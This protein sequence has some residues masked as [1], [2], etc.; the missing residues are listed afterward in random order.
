MIFYYKKKPRGSSCNALYQ[1]FAKIFCR[2]ILFVSTN[3]FNECFCLQEHTGGHAPELLPLIF[4]QCKF[5]NRIARPGDLERRDLSFADLFQV[6]RGGNRIA[7]AE[8]KSAFT[9]HGA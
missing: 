3:L 8:M 2:Q 6:G 4:I 9:V 1:W 5:R 7:E